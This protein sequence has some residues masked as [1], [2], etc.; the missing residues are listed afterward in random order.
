[1][2]TD[3]GKTCLMQ[4]ISGMP[5]FAGLF[6]SNNEEKDSIKKCVYFGFDGPSPL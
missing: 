4:I 2:D 3:A 6:Q 1:M 5:P